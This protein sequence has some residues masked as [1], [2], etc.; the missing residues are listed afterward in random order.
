[1][2]SSKQQIGVFVERGLFRQLKPEEAQLPESNTKKIR[3]NPFAAKESWSH[4]LAKLLPAIVAGSAQDV[5]QQIN[6]IA[7]NM[8]EVC[9]YDADTLLAAVHLSRGYA[10]TVVHPVHTAILC[11]LLGKR[12][13]LS[14]CERASIIAAALTMNLGMLELQDVLFAQKTPLTDSQKKEIFLHPSGSVELLKQAGVCDELWLEAVEFHHEKVDGSG[15]PKRLLGAE[16]GQAA[17]IIAL[18]DMYSALVTPRAH[19]TSLMP[20]EALKSIFEK[21]GE[22]VDDNLATQL[23][24]EVGVFP[25]GAYVR[26]ANGDTAVVTKRAVVKKDRD[27][28]APIVYSLISPRGGIYEFPHERDCSQA[29]FKITD[30]CNPELPESVDPLKIWDC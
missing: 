21:R 1:M 10:Y 13:E 28:T 12:L 9:D 22:I 3:M 23:I 26:L 7:H 5:C 11:E 8:Q 17:K 2:I 6:C 19:R 15:Y 27:S 18:A 4:K 16:I 29:L 25:P 20:K 30:I 24:R 14:S